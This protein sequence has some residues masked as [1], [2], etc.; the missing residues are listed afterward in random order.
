MSCSWSTF[1]IKMLNFKHFWLKCTFS[2]HKFGFY[3]S[4]PYIC[5]I[6][7]LKTFLHLFTLFEAIAYIIHNSIPAPQKC[8]TMLLWN[9]KIGDEFLFDILNVCHFVI[10]K[11]VIHTWLLFM[12]SL[13]F[14]KN[15]VY[16]HAW[17]FSDNF[18]YTL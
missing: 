18:V 6:G 17:L 13:F 10:S 14:E 8:I 9:L 5:V 12:V 7:Q 2:I 3:D 4:C 16:Y 1:I 15:A 11:S